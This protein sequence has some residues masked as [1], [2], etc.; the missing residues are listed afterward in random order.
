MKLFTKLFRGIW[1]LNPFRTYYTIEIEDGNFHTY[2]HFMLCR[3]WLTR[4]LT[5]DEAKVGIAKYKAKKV[6]NVKYKVELHD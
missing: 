3:S 1:K 6:P 2:E 4:Y 5:L